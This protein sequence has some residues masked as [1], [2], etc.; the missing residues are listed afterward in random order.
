MHAPRIKHMLTMK[1]ISFYVLDTLQYD[2]YLYHSLIEKL[3]SY[4]DADWGGCPDTRRF[5][6]GYYVFSY[7]DSL[8]LLSSKIQI[9]FSHY[10]AK[11][12][13]QC[14]ANMVSESCQLRNL[15][16]ELHFP[17]SQATSVYCDNVSAI[18]LSD[19]LVQHQ[20]T[21][22]IEMY[23]HFTREKDARGQTCVLHVLFWHKIVDIFTKDLLRVLFDDFKT[24]LNARQPPASMCR[25][26]IES[27]CHYF[28]INL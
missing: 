15:L 27:L 12:E 18:Y 5:T 25:G 3:V 21:E 9:I 10:S 26:V 7:G 16:L 4:S 24:S 23:I 13:Y 28:I 19:N 6:F 1:C 2:L 8:T 20:R 11:T 14:V 17:L 22:Y